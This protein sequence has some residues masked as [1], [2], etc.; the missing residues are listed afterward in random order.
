MRVLPN[1]TGSVALTF[2]STLDAAGTAAKRCAR[3]KESFWRSYLAEKRQIPVD[4]RRCSPIVAGRAW[5]NRHQPH[6]RTASSAVRP[7]FFVP[8]G[9]PPSVRRPEFAIE[10]ASYFRFEGV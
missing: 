2:A 7:W 5:L 10:P 3:A 4:R 6:W 9:L 8:H 1:V